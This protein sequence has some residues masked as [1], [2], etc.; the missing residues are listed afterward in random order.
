LASSPDPNDRA[1]V[2]TK[3][4]DPEV[5][6]S[7]LWALGFA[8]DVDSAEVLIE[9]LE[10]AGQVAG[11]ALSAITGVV[12]EGSLRKPGETHGPDQEEVGLD[13]PPP[14]VRTEDALPEPVVESLR[15]WW[16]KARGRFRPGMRY[17]YGQPRSPETLQAALTSA[18]T[19][20]RE[21]FALELA[22]TKAGLPK[23]DLQGW[24]NEQLK[25][26]RRA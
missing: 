14:E 6:V 2:R 21:I 11:E 8:G 4:A 17:L 25:Q 19:W 16:S 10:E 24:A 26:L 22:S 15:D 12:V 7:A 9:A 1:L 20:R 13:D 23:V 18:P 5:A 3:V